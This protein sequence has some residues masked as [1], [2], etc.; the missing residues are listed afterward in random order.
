MRQELKDIEKRMSDAVH[1]L[2]QQIEIDKTKPPIK[3]L[4]EEMRAVLAEISS[5]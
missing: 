1:A 2:E 3:P 4:V 5:R